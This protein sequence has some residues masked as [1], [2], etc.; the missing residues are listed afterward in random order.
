[1]TLPI[2]FKILPNTTVIKQE[3][4]IGIATEERPKHGVNCR[5]NMHALCKN[6]NTHLDSI[7]N[8]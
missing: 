8:S 1:M 4:V 6:S 3:D 5:V 7:P 2:P